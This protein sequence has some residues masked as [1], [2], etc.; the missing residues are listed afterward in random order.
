[1][2][3]GEVKVVT[4]GRGVEGGVGYGEVVFTNSE[5]KFWGLRYFGSS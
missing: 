1:M 2:M 5:F 3:I 4:R